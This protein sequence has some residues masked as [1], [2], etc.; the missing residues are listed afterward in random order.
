MLYILILRQEICIGMSVNLGEL[1]KRQGFPCPH[2]EGIWGSKGI[3]ALILDLD[4]A[5]KKPLYP[6]SRRL[7]VPHVES[8]RFGESMKGYLKT[9]SK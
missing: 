3:A 9:S 7:V 5:G 4:T 6:F 1:V 2:P 8:G